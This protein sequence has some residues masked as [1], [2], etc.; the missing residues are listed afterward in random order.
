MTN[1]SQGQT[2]QVTNKPDRVNWF[3]DLACLYTG[4]EDNSPIQR[5]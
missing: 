5:G 1:K 4:N 3:Q 2:I